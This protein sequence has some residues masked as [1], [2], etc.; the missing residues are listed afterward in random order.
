MSG[1]LEKLLENWLDSASERSYQPVFVQMLAADGYTVLH[2]TRHCLLEFGKDILAIGP[3]GV[4]CAFQLKGDPGGRMTIGTFRDGIQQQLVQLMSQSPSYPGFPRGAHR[5]YLVSNGQFEEEVQAAVREMNDGPYPAKVE[6]WSRGKLLDLCNR[7]GASLWPGE[8]RDTRDLLELYLGNPRDQVPIRTLAEMLS[9]VLGL[10][11][12]VTPFGR[13]QLGRAASSAV[14]LTGISTAPFAEAE[15]HQAVALGWT[16]C[17]VMLIGAAEKHA[18]GDMKAVQTSF[19]LAASTVL[20]ALAALWQEVRERQHLV[21]GDA[22]TD[23][24]VYGWRIGV[25]YGLLSSLAI[26]AKDVPVL[27]DDSRHALSQWLKT[28]THQ[29]DLWGEAAVANLIPR[30]L[31]LRTDDPT[32]RPDLE[33]NALTSAVITRNQQKS[34]MSLPSPYYT[35]EEVFR[36]YRDVY[37]LRRSVSII[38]QETFP[39]N[40]YTAELLFHLLVRTGLKQRCKSLWPAFSRL[41]HRQ[42][43]LDASWHYC[44]VTTPSG[45]EDTKLYK[46]TYEWSQLKQ[47]SLQEEQPS[48][49]PEELRKNPWLLAMWWQVA[50]HRLNSEATRVFANA[51]IP[52]WGM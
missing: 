11:A 4:G 26:A 50:P 43:R 48:T 12:D 40:S 18:Q 6:L 21:E 23:P 29:L 44:T 49:V 39:G 30:L 45:I 25:L 1:V 17:C 2:S 27:D 28:G 14:W 7:R 3:D 24:E 8:L 46:P 35:F 10:A 16:L 51:L 36:H 13:P 47:D 15:N 31:W 9:S 22:L 5:A 20:D 52:K 42:L 38:E 32:L 41:G 34:L 37:G 19:T 33:I